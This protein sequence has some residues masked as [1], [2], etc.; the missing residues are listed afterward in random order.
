MGML[1]EVRA[2]RVVGCVALWLWVFSAVVLPQSPPGPPPVGT[3]TISGVVTDGNSG[4]PVSGALVQ[5]TASVPYA[6]SRQMTDSRGRFVFQHLA[7]DTYGVHVTAPGY[8]D[9][10]YGRVPGSTAAGQIKLQVRQWFGDAGAVLWKPASI[11]GTIRDERG[12]PLV[13]VPVRILM[14]FGFGGR[15]QWAA[16][17]VTQTD[18]RGAYRFAGLLPGRYSVFVPSMQI[19]LPGGQ[20]A[21]YRS[22]NVEPL[23]VIRAPDGIGTMAGFFAVAPSDHG[24]VYPGTFYPAARSLSTADV[25]T[26]DAGSDRRAVDISLAPVSSVRVSGVVAGPA[27]AVADL[28]VRL[29]PAGNAALGFGF[30]TALTRTDTAGKFTLVNVPQGDYALVAERAHSRISGATGQTL[31]WQRLAQAALAPTAANSIRWLWRSVS[32]R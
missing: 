19:T 29:L 12:E 25:V 13:D 7:A 5:L 22:L 15:D 24:Q 26:L 21:L 23:P 20:V 31:C 3:G 32:R 16:W 1:R 18:D 27:D 17:A 4:R 9:G 11:S 30:E 2:G 8:L 28:P 6:R 14:A 10:G